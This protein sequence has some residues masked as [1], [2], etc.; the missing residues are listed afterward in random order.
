MVLENASLETKYEEGRDWIKHNF[1]L[2]GISGWLSVFEMNV[3]LVGSL[4]TV[5]AFAGDDMYEEKAQEV[6]DKLLPAFR[7]PMGIPYSLIHV[8]SRNSKNDID[9]DKSCD[10][11]IS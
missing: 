11:N 7:S 8:E 9:C 1:T 10:C 6:V 5:Y 2:D 3:R 4:L